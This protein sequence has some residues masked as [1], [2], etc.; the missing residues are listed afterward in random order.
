MNR[1]F[2]FVA[3]IAGSAAG[4]FGTWYYFFTLSSQM[5]SSMP[6]S[7]QGMMDMMMG[8]AMVPAGMP[9]APLYTIIPLAFIA[10]LVIGVAGLS[11]SMLFPEIRN[12]P[13]SIQPIAQKEQK[14]STI[15]KTLSV[16]EQKVIEVILVHNGK[17]LQKY[18]VKESGLTRLKVHR[19]LARLAER[20]IVNIRE[21]ANTNEVSIAEWLQKEKEG[22]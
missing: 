12:V 18:V 17:Y 6:S 4:L 14:L 8:G 2:L 7:M 21:Y 3:L 19:I 16:E 22:S 13:S 11:Y 15:M 9:F 1:N 5:R 10:I 20:G